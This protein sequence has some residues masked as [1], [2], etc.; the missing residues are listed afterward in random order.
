MQLIGFRGRAAGAVAALAFSCVLTLGAAQG[1]DEKALVMKISIPTINDALHQYAK[2]LGARVEKDS[3]GRIKAEVYPASQLGSISRQIE[4]T[5]FGS[6]QFAIEPPEFFVGVDKRFEIL[7]APGLISSIR[8][9]QRV[10]A[11]PTVQKLMF[12]LGASKGL[13]GVG[14][15]VALPAVVAFNLI[16]KKVAEVETGVQVLGKL[17]GA[18]LESLERSGAP[19]PGVVVSEPAAEDEPVAAT[20]AQA[21]EGA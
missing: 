3:G 6:I 20:A 9:A 11:D 4:G 8:N 19:L 14:L 15:F 16:Q 21:T 7:S 5:Q 1:A 10:T 12:G 17:A 13:H 18:Y 2:T